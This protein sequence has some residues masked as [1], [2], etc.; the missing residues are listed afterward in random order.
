MKTA[1][2]RFA[3]VIVGAGLA[4]LMTAAIANVGTLPLPDPVILS[5]LTAGLVALD[6]FLRDKGV[7]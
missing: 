1:L 5:L 4:A 2:L 6:K 7:Y 3:R